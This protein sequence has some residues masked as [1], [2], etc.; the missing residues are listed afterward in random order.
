M[1]R[2]CTECRNTFIKLKTRKSDH[3]CGGVFCNTFAEY[4]RPNHQ[5]FMKMNRGTPRTKD[6]L[7]IFFDLET[8]EDEPFSNDPETKIH[9]V[10]LGVRQR[11]CTSVL[12]DSVVKIVV[13]IQVFLKKTLSISL[14]TML[15]K[16][17]KVQT[18]VLT[19]S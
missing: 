18:L 10:S 12:Q 15:W 17:G 3:V 13:P 7:F 9:K 4:T 19:R 11:F 2:K 6:F 1:L 8:H 14:W 5:C 16:S